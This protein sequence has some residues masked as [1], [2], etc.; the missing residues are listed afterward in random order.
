MKTEK[1]NDILL[2]GDFVDFQYLGL[3]HTGM[4]IG[5]AENAE[6]LID[7]KFE[8]VVCNGLTSLAGKIVLGYKELQRKDDKTQTILKHNLSL[9]LLG[10]TKWLECTSYNHNF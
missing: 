3:S 1:G 7:R 2:L 8:I 10:Y 9:F 6:N 4:I 5:L